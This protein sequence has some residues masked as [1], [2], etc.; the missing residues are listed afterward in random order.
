MGAINY[1]SNEIINLGINTSNI[2]N[3]D[4]FNEV[5]YIYD[6]VKNILD[7]YSFYYYHV[8]IKEGYYS[9]LYLDIEANFYIYD[10]YLDKLDAQKELTQ[11]KELLNRC[12][13]AGLVCYTPGWCTG[14]YDFKDTKTKI[15]EAIKN[16]RLVVKAAPTDYTY[17]EF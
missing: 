10:S 15:K 11:L 14:Y 16:A 2:L 12:A 9:G 17:K 13:G 4:D 7:D 3:E 5:S 8:V 6:D 1:G